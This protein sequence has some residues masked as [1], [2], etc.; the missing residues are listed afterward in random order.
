[1][2]RLQNF[3]IADP[4]LPDCPIVFASDPFLRLTGYRRE[5]VLGRNCRFLQG[6]DTDRAA[7]LELK[8]AIRAGREC[9]VRLLNYTKTGKAFW[10]MLTVAPIKD[11]EDRPRFLVGVQVDVTEHPTVADATPVGRQAA[12][13]VGQALQSMNW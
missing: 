1:L 2:C 13:A 8:A 7:V 6:P 4:T 10:N 5:E 3:V 9:T 11:I 12:N